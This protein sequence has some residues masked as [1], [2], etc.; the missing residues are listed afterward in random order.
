MIEH[1][2]LCRGCDCRVLAD[3]GYGDGYN[4]ECFD[5]RAEFDQALEARFNRLTWEEIT[6]GWETALEEMNEVRRNTAMGL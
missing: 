6:E 3:E 2:R 1:T 4:F 5:C